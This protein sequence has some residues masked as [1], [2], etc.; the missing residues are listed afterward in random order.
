MVQIVESTIGRRYGGWFIRNTEHALK[1]YDTIRSSPL[2]ISKVAAPE[3]D[4]NAPT[5]NSAAAVTGSNVP[6]APTAKSA[7]GAAKTVRLAA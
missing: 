5:A 4:G 2:P 1:V 6:K 7:W 3:P